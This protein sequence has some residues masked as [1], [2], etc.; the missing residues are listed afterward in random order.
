MTVKL[1]HIMKWGRPDLGT[2]VYF[3]TM[4]VTERNV[5][6]WKKDEERSHIR[7]KYNKR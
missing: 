3:L 6:N 1:L 5:D 7:E 2:M 4:R